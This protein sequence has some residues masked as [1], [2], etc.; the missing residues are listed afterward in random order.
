MR[1]DIKTAAGARTRLVFRLFPEPEK[2][3]VELHVRTDAGVQ[4]FSPSAAE[5]ASVLLPPLCAGRY[6]YD[7]CLSGQ[8]LLHGELQVRPSALWGG[9]AE[10]LSVVT[11][12]LPLVAFVLNPGPR[13]EIG[14]QG[15]QGLSAYE[16]AAQHGYDGSEADWVAELQGAQAAAA[17]AKLQAQQSAQAATSASGYASAAGTAST[18]AAA[19]AELAGVQANTATGAA[20]TAKEYRTLSLADAEAA[21]TSAGAAAGS[22]K[23]AA[24]SAAAATDS[25]EYAATSASAAFQSATTARQD[26]ADAQSFASAADNSAA[27]AA[28]SATAAADTLAAAPKLNGINTFEGTNTF[29]GMLAANGGITGLPQPS[30]DTAA[31]SRD[32]AYMADIYMQT[33]S[34]TAKPELVITNGAGTLNGSQ[35]GISSKAKGLTAAEANN[36]NART[37]FPAGNYHYVAAGY[38]NLSQVNLDKGSA[39]RLMLNL[40]ER[41]SMDY[42]GTNLAIPSLNWRDFTRT[43]IYH[44]AY[45]E[46]TVQV[47]TDDNG[48]NVMLRGLNITGTE[49]TGMRECT[50]RISSTPNDGGQPVTGVGT[51]NAQGIIGVFFAF[52]DTSKTCK[53]FLVPD[54]GKTN[55]IFIGEL[56]GNNQLQSSYPRKLQIIADNAD[57]TCDEITL[58][59][60]LIDDV[61]KGV[62]AATNALDLT[63]TDYTFAQL[64]GI[65]PEP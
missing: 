1:Y 35:T 62:L 57:V 53:V 50:S 65:Y 39:F 33:R 55:P 54:A 25:A 49:A 37:F 38:V 3:E 42:Q 28:N 12:D 40:S 6:L 32:A 51:S 7:F 47:H 20:T 2:T 30:S 18:A 44:Y 23:A 15:P 22:A 64:E 45:I 36:F 14:A 8:V 5:P 43:G 46:I 24:D 27:A 29:N 58:W 21:A 13:G 61:S 59:R 19:A 60:G 16:L 26:A 56:H 11:V 17:E 10:V 48:A 4:S 52:Y 41:T 9:C 63:T 34:V 31:M